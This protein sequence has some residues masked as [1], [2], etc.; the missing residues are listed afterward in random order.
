MKLSGPLCSAET[1]TPFAMVSV[2]SPRPD[3]EGQSECVLDSIAVP[4]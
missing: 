3:G 2:T 4:T 1:P